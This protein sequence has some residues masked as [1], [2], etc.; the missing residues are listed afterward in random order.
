MRRIPSSHPL[1]DGRRAFTLLELLVVIAIIAI[2]AA[3]LLPALRYAKESAR[4]SVCASNL[5]QLGVALQL[6]LDDYLAYFPYQNDIGTDRLWYFGLESPFNASGAPGARHIDLT[7]AKLYPYFRTLHGIEICPSYDYRSPLWRQKYDQ[8]TDGYGFNWY[9]YA[10]LGA[11]VREPSRILCFADS[12]QI[13]AIQAPASSTHPML[14]EWYYVDD[15]YPLVHFRHNGRANVLFCDS[16]VESRS[17]APGTLD[18]R[19]RG[20][21]VGRLNATGDS[22]LFQ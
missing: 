2:V 15:I 10:I 19:I 7:K 8:I 18:S 6:Y 11:Q 16:R 20:A 12:A 13:N 21:Q 22:S 14:E 1:F 4:A 17:M 9:L 5:R 3:M